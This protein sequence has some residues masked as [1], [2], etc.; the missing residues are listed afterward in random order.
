MQFGNGIF[1]KKDFDQIDRIM[2]LRDEIMGMVSQPEILVQMAEEAAELAQACL[3]LRRAIRKD[4]PTPVT[5][6]EAVSR[7]TE[8]M[9]DVTLCKY[10]LAGDYRPGS[11]DML[12]IMERK[13]ARWVERLREGKRE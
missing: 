10:L 3:K 13:A 4:N 5:K 1:K 12:E 7:L 9:A 2:N 8:E 6:E 11:R